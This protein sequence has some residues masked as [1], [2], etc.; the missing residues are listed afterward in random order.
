MIGNGAGIWA[1]AE[2][3]SILIATMILIPEPIRHKKYTFF[4]DKLNSH[5]F[6]YRR[7]GTG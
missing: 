1:G 7:A 2:Q 6:N 3:K 4:P 5:V